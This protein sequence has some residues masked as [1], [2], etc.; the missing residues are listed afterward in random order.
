MALYS[1][2]HGTS[3]LKKCPICGNNTMDNDGECH[4][5]YCDE[6][7]FTE[8]EEPEFD[9]AGFSVADREGLK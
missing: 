6:E 4:Y 9:G 2:E 1:T 7:A 5:A 3:S 8:M